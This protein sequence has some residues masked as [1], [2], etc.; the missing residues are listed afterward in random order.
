M[1]TWK[2]WAAMAA[3]T[4]PYAI[5]HTLHYNGYHMTMLVFVTCALPGNCF[6]S[7]QIHLL[8]GWTSP[9]KQ[10]AT[11]GS[12]TN[13]RP[14]TIRTQQGVSRRVTGASQ[15]IYVCLW[16]K[17]VHGIYSALYL[18]FLLAPIVQITAGSLNICS[19]G[20]ITPILNTSFYQ[21]SKNCSDRSIPQAYQHCSCLFSGKLF[22]LL[23]LHWL[24]TKAPRY[25]HWSAFMHG[26]PGMTMHRR[27]INKN[28]MSGRC[29]L[30][31]ISTY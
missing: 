14:A 27:L 5:E 31:Q 2:V 30:K 8:I 24:K 4:S 28:W 3:Q 13:D 9:R 10:A 1:C 26:R 17:Q 12:F 25:Q 20:S 18:K 15:D 21:R 19:K 6:L 23:L 16:S 7:L 11:A 29:T 22:Y